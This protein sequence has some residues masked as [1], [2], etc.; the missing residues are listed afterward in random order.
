MFHIRFEHTCI[1]KPI[2]TIFNYTL[3][4]TYEN[5]QFAFCVKNYFNGI[6]YTTSMNIIY[7]WLHLGI[8]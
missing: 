4:Y 8:V 2:I 5:A 3:C 7:N 6:R 1:I